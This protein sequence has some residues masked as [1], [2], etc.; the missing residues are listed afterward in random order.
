MAMINLHVDKYEKKIT[1]KFKSGGLHERH[2]IA[3]WKVGNYLSIRLW[4]Q[5]NQENTR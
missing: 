5:E 2:V 1:R 3:T 4:T